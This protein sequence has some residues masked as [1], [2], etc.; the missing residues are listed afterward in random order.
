MTAWLSTHRIQLGGRSSLALNTSRLFNRGPFGDLD[1]L[2]L[3]G[4]AEPL[5]GSHSPICVP[6]Y[7]LG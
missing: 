2:N 5:P 1:I 4:E 3:R 6:S 7:G